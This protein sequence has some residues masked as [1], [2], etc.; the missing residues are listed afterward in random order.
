MTESEVYKQLRE[1][2]KEIRQLKEE[3]KEVCR[4]CSN[5]NL[6]AVDKI[7]PIYNIICID[8]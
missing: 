7:T 1:A 6:K 5:P 4:I 8:N 2:R 3:R